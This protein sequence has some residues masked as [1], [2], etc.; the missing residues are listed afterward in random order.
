MIEKNEQP[1][2]G[3]SYQNGNWMPIN[4]DNNW[5]NLPIYPNFIDAAF[6][7]S[8]NGASKIFFKSVDSLDKFF[9]FSKFAVL[10]LFK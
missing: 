5:M 1:Y 7:N 6:G 9:I 2:Q 10:W 3:T 4:F 8:D